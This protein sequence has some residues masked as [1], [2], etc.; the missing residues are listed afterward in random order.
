MTDRTRFSLAALLAT[1]LS[2]AAPG[3]GHSQ[4]YPSQDIHFIVGFAPGSGPDVITRWVA[5]KMRPSIGR[6]IV[7]E[8]KVGAGGNIATEY[9]ARA[10]PDGY[11]V[12]MTGGSALAASGHLFRN[13]SIDVSKGFETVAMLAR[14]PTLLVVGP[15]SP[16]KTV[17]D[18]QAALKSKGSK[19]SYGTAFPTARVLGAM[20]R[21]SAG[22]QAVEVQYR[23]SADWIN[24]LASGTL[25]FAFIDAASGV[26][27]AA[28][29]RIRIMAVSLADRF[30]T[31]PNIP[32]LK[33]SGINV[34]VSGWWAAFVA[35]GTPKPIV[36]KL[37]KAFTEA[38]K[39]PEAKTFF[40]GISNE[41]WPMSQADAQKFYLR[42]YKDWGDYVRLAK[43][44]PQG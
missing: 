17:A 2:V 27:H 15:N 32:T 38:V 16:Y 20:V 10:K 40:N 36:E 11:T 5:E 26:G 30:S 25:D 19:G 24:D 41:P 28:Q 13:L 21:D 8:N 31:M 1:A 22:G 37:H 3:I 4:E 44:E 42:E 34:D 29:N 9:V 39:T 18:L 6:T 33:E 35:E 7:I 14:Q 23:T 12:Y 43:I